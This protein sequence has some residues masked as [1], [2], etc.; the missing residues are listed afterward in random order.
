LIVASPVTVMPGIEPV[1]QHQAGSAIAAPATAA[2]CGGC[3]EP[4]GSSDDLVCPRAVAAATTSTSAEAITVTTIRRGILL[5]GFI[6]SPFTRASTF[7]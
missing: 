5:N 6:G 7:R 4:D 3:S 2:D 1:A